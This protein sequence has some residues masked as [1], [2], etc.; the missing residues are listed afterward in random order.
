LNPTLGR[1]MNIKACI[2]YFD[3]KFDWW[4]FSSS[5]WD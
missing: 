3:Q 2:S 5:L 1:D 4:S